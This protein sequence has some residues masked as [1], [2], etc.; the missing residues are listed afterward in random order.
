MKSFKFFL[1]GILILLVLFFFRPAIAKFLISLRT[2][3]LSFLDRA[4][5]YKSFNDLRLEREKLLYEIENL[6]KTK[7][8][9]KF[10]YEEAEVFSYYPWNNRASLVIALGTEDG[11]KENFPVL[12]AS[13][14]LLGKI[15]SVKRTQSEVL[16]IFDPSWRSSVAI[17]DSRTNALLKGGTEPHLEL[18]PQE[19]KVIA[20]DGVLN[21]S[22]D[23]PIN[24]RF[25]EI[26]EL[27]KSPKD[28]WFSAEL[29]VPYKFENLGKVIVL[30]NF[31]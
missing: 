9:Q 21:L 24:Y 8:I 23:F 7:P 11:I 31:P 17:G 26:A 2:L 3:T 22:S 28:V 5:D 13:G 18:I 6:K 1:A 25:G 19:A 30:K 4:F 29:K 20:G 14:V 15:K 10:D 12:A 27:K 16:T